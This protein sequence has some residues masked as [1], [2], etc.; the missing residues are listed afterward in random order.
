MLVFAPIVFQLLGCQSGFQCLIL[1]ESPKVIRSLCDWNSL[2]H[3]LILA[4][5]MLLPE[6]MKRIVHSVSFV[7][8]SDF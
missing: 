5:K 8:A 2:I 1:N 3:C 6:V 4:M 7:N